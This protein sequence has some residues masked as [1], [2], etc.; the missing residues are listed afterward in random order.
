MELFLFGGRRGKAGQRDMVV[1]LMNQLPWS[2]LIQHPAESDLNQVIYLVWFHKMDLILCKYLIRA[3]QPL[4][5]SQFKQGAHAICQPE[6]LCGLDECW[7]RWRVLQASSY[8]R[9]CILNGPCSTAKRWLCSCIAVWTITVRRKKCW[10]SQVTVSF[11]QGTNW[12][13]QLRRWH[14][15]CPGAHTS[16]LPYQFPLNRSR[17][18]CVCSCGKSARGAP[19]LQGGG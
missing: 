6:S 4:K 1:R 5:S 12:W 18:I 16:V 3:T 7:Q 8:Y 19:A 2:L 17:Q 11:S 14:D 9:Q 10:P 13:Q 15:L